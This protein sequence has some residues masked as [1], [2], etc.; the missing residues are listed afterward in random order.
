MELMSVHPCG[1]GNGKYLPDGEYFA[2]AGIAVIDTAEAGEIEVCVEVMMFDGGTQVTAYL[3]DDPIRVRF[4]SLHRPPRA[5]MARRMAEI[6][7][8]TGEDAMKLIGMAV[9][10]VCDAARREQ[11]ARPWRLEC[12]RRQEVEIEGTAGQTVEYE[13]KTYTLTGNITWDEEADILEGKRT[14]DAPITARAQIESEKSGELR[15][16][17]WYLSGEEELNAW[18]EKGNWSDK[19][20]GILTLDDD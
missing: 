11:Q 14:Y 17:E 13:G 4:H 5:G 3:G 15:E 8:Y 18:M 9:D 20:T 12:A 16:I 7:D 10:A 19:I 1:D 2:P 6:A